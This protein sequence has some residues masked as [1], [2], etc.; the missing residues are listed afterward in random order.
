MTVDNPNPYES[1]ADQPEPLP[2]SDRPLDWREGLRAILTTVGG[3][4]L[5]FWAAYAWFM[6]GILWGWPLGGG[7]GL[8]LAG[9]MLLFWWID[10]SR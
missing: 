7:M 9:G 4:G 6:D 3:L 1:P 8:T 5:L 10:D 2:A